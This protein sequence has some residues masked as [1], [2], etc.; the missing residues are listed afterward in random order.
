MQNIQ[1]QF[2]FI[3]EKAKLEFRLGNLEGAEAIAEK[4]LNQKDH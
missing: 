3:V 2:C 4:L 1:E